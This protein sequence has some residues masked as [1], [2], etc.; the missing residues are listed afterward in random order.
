MKKLLTGCGLLIAILLTTHESQAQEK[1]WGP[2]AGIN[3]STLVDMPLNIYKPGVNFGAFL[4]YSN[5]ERTGLKVEAMYSQ[6]GTKFDG[7]ED[8]IEM[9]YVQVPVYGVWYLNDRGNN[10]RPKL[11]VGPY[12]GF[13]LNATGSNTTDNNF[14]TEN[15]NTVDFGGKGAVGFNWK[16]S[17]RVW[18]NSEFY[19]GGSFANIYSTD[20][21]NVKNTNFG[22]NA[23]LSFPLDN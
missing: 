12:L 7:F 6:M 10:F 1:S 19:F 9:H 17:P 22:V 23:G 2:M 5:R 16:F 11:M 4:N 21:I 8:K 3:G 18:L 15:F 13:L 20:I 14:T